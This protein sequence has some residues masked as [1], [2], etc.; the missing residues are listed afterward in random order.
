MNLALL[1]AERIAEQVADLFRLL[2][3]NLAIPPVRIQRRCLEL[4]LAVPA[5]FRYLPALMS[6]DR[7]PERQEPITRFD[8]LE[9][10][11]R[12]GEKPPEHHR[13]GM[14]HEKIGMVDGTLLPI[15]YA[16]PHGI[17]ELLERM[18]RFGFTPFRED[19]HAIAALQGT[20]SISLE[21]GGQLELSGRPFVCC[22]DLDQELRRH[23]AIVHALG[24]E[25]GHRWL[26]V[27]YRPFGSVADAQWMPKGR[28]RRMADFLSRTGDLA[29]DMMTMT[30]TVQANYDYR[31]EADM[32]RKMR[33][34]T[35]IS[36]LVT[37]LFANSPLREGK[38]SG[39]LSF[40]S[41]VWRRVDPLRCGPRPEVFEPGFGY[42][43]Y[44]AWALDVPTI[45]LRRK[46]AYVDPGGLTFR[47]LVDVGY[48]GERVTTSDWEDH[49][50]TLFPEVR[51]K[52]VIEVRGADV[53]TRDMCVALPALWKGLLYD[54]EALAAAEALVPLAFAERLALHEQV[55]RVA[56][57][58]RVGT[59]LVLD[60]CRE[61]VDL[62]AA[63]L[64][65]RGRCGTDEVR[66]LE[67]LREI[68]ADGRCPAEIAL[69]R[70]NGEYAGDATKLLDHWRVA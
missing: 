8:Q 33:G 32:A 6:L 57:R 41:E 4:V 34:A 14:E 39:Y 36:P 10:Y 29:L 42:A 38:D 16:G 11:F 68:L 61:L 2:Y 37:A 54:H 50:S 35:A 55:A 53:G 12:L 13:V 49:L 31:D 44:A 47:Q 26:G 21:P 60:L 22:H 20:L 40:R 58:A 45:F 28:Y 27:G 19:G 30:A 48:A 15:P 17:G 46:G 63:G 62:A 52:R 18:P 5:P 7:P 69:A 70:L 51:L 64:S 9:D 67:P 24:A 3:L 59:H 66:F 65:R 1:E 56:L 23:L 25:L 43:A